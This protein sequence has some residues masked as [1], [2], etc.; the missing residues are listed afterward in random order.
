MEAEE[1]EKVYEKMMT[2]KDDLELTDVQVTQIEYLDTVMI[3]NIDGQMEPK[4]L[5]RVLENRDGVL[6][7]FYYLE[8]Q[9]VA[10]QDENLGLI[11]VEE[12]SEDLELVP[13]L[14]EKSEEEPKM[15]FEEE[16]DKQEEKMAQAIGV[17]QEQISS[18]TE[19]DVNA[20]ITSSENFCDL[21][22]EAKNFRRV[23]AVCT[24]GKSAMFHFVGI[25]NE[26][27][28]KEFTTLN[29][30]EGVS[31]TK[32]VKSMNRDGTEI[33]DTTVSA[34][35][36]LK[37]EMNEGLSIKQ[38]Q[39]GEIEV[40]YVRRDPSSSQYLASPVETNTQK[41]TT[42]EVKEMMDTS[43]NTE[44]DEEI[45]RANKE[46]KAH[47]KVEIR[48]IDD[49]PN[50]DVGHEHIVRGEDGEEIDLEEIAK[51]E[52][53]SVEDLREKIERQSDEISMEDKIDNAIEEINEEFRHP[54]GRRE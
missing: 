54:E 40:Q 16:Q 53:V 51:R 8:D 5:F 25:T 37:G 41:P 38:G 43:K 45:D 7:E 29:P 17:K 34:M 9:K 35:Y 27:E 36:L 32:S 28:V 21:V 33:E 14:E 11:P 3:K 6:Q 44:I 15:N 26:G 42:Y 2:I 31:P 12:V 20:K 48:N 23:R 13:M 52:N 18:Y 47:G 22:P 10:M 4:A 46:E 30:T 50:N 19:I 49:N 39:Y 24:S 1:Q